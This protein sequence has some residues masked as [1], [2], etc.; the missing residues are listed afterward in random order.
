MMRS[1]IL[2]FTGIVGLSQICA[3]EIEAVVEKYQNLSGTIEINDIA[4]D[5]NNNKW[6]ASDYGLVKIGSINSDP[7][8]FPMDTTVLALAADDDEMIW[9]ALGNNQILD[10]DMEVVFQ[11]TPPEARITC[12]TFY[13]SLL[14][15]GTDQGLFTYNPRVDRASRIYTTDNSRIPNNMINML[16][17]DPYDQ[18]WIGT[19]EGVVQMRKNSMK[20]LEQDHRFQA[21]T[22]TREGIWLVSDKEIWVV[23]MK[24]SRTGRWY[25]ADVSRGL[26]K[27]KVRA[28]AADSKGRIYLASQIL[29]QFDPYSNRAT[30]FD[31]DYGFVSSDVLALLCDK[32]DDLWVGTGDHGLFR[33]DVIEGEFEELSAVAFVKEELI[34][35]GREDGSVALKINGGKEPYSIKWNTGAR[36]KKQLRGIT[37]GTYTATI[38]DADGQTYVASTELTQP[39]SIEIRELVNQRVSAFRARDGR[40]KVDVAGGTKPYT[41]RWSNGKRGILEQ[42]NLRYGDYTLTVIDANRCEA[43]RTFEIDKPKVLPQLDI[44][45]IEVG[46]TLKIEEL[47][48]EADSA[49][50]EEDSYA[51]LD[52]IYEFLSNHNNVFVEIGGHTNLKPSHEYSD[53]LSTARAKNVAEYLYQKGIPKEQIVYKGY[54]KRQPIVRDLRSPRQELNQRVELKILEIK[55]N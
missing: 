34:C 6:L 44:S 41:L 28:L 12:M 18:L 1:F 24:E 42:E 46:Q 49:Y 37:A 50:V 11:V 43:E 20:V 45:T 19:E 22:H 48:F 5:A 30:V 27:G 29:V 10:P 40:L 8:I 2:L 13:R 36:E 7:E 31:E 4:I 9:S 47:Y 32:N 17:A 35:H 21:A 26:S 33:I 38:T 39:D 15:I 54:G 51:V 25:P 23:N 14:Y 16:F 3:Q 52:E 55:N 53:R